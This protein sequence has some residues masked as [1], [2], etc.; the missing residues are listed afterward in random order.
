MLTLGLGFVLCFL[1]RLLLLSPL[2]L[3]LGFW[4]P[5]L[6]LLLLLVLLG[7]S[8]FNFACAVGSSSGFTADVRDV[9][10][11]SLHSQTHSNKNNTDA[12][13][14]NYLSALHDV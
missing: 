10:S 14:S 7:A 6:L 1:L 13:A 8:G 11:V 5:S 12:H 4:L 3:L 2:L 9:C